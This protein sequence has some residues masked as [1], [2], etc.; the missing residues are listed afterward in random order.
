VSVLFLKNGENKS[1][2]RLKRPN[3]CALNVALA[4]QR[5]AG[6]D[7]RLN[8]EKTAKAWSVRFPL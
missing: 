6:P 3:R 4:V 7:A 1:L 2:E 5:N 8:E